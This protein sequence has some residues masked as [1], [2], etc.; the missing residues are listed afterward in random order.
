VEKGLTE[1][2]LCEIGVGQMLEE[3]GARMI[4]E[5]LKCHNCSLTELNLSCDKMKG[6]ERTKA[7]MKIKLIGRKKVQLEMMEGGSIIYCDDRKR[8]LHIRF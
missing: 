3:T 4:S 5:A 7:K 1:K 2:H 8:A 6:T